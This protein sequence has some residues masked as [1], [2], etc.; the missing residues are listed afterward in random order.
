MPTRYAR[1]RSRAPIRRAPRRVVDVARFDFAAST[2][3]NAT[4]SSDVFSDYN[5]SMGILVHPPGITIVG[6]R[7]S[8]TVFSATAI[9]VGYT[10]GFIVTDQ[11]IAAAQLDPDTNR[12]LDFMEWGFKT[13][14]V[15]P[16]PLPTPVLV[17]NGD[18]GFRTVRSMRKLHEQ[19][20][21]LAFMIRSDS[22]TATTF[23]V[24]GSV[25]FKLP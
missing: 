25:H 1:G 18:D 20:N 14:L 8:L 13:V 23:A 6:I 24:S 17:G 3:V 5:A 12:H 11:G 22:A 21:N 15:G 16:S 10:W 4:Q 2:L 9:F 7:Y 19:R